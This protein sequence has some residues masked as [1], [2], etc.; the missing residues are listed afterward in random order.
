MN[1]A[2]FSVR[3]AT[4][5]RRHVAS[6]GVARRDSRSPVR[7]PAHRPTRSSGVGYALGPIAARVD[8]CASDPIAVHLQWS[9]SMQKHSIRVHSQALP[10]N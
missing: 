9:L 7:S 2:A 1:L 5:A 6:A 10:N 3:C 8:Q 4:R